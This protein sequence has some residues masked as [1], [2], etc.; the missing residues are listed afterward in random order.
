MVAGVL[1]DLDGTLLDID[2]DNFLGRYLHELSQFV[3]DVAEGAVAPEAVQHAV[4]SGTKAMMGVHEG[5]NREA[6]NERVLELVG[7]DLATPR[8]VDALD[9]FYGERFP[10]LRGELGPIQGARD[11]VEAA[12]ELGLPIALATHP[13]FPVA[14]IRERLRWAELDDIPFAALTTYE[15][16]GATKPHAAYFASTAALIGVDPEHCIMVGDDLELDLPARETG[17]RVFHHDPA[18][19]GAAGDRADWAGSMADFATLL[20][21]LV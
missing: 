1:F 5:T 15:T 3:A 4:L 18:R 19:T 9:Y 11:A 7:L 14:A 13:V 20:P 16:M 10:A 17:M 21:T 8:Y 6:F 2:I 12:V